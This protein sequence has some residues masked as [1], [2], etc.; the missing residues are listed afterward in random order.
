M[1]AGISYN[2]IST[3]CTRNPLV[4]SCPLMSLDLSHNSLCNAPEPL[5]VLAQLPQLKSLSLKGNPMCL[6]PDYQAVVLSQLPSLVYLDDQVRWCLCFNS[7][8]LLC[9]PCPQAYLQ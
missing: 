9:R 5:H 7:S 3:L 6:Q 2:T 1:H 4:N 8:K